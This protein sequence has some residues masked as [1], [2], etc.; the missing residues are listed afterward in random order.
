MQQEADRQRAGGKRIGLVPTMG[1]L[2]EG[3]TS[4][5][6]EAR[7]ISDIVVLS[8]F[9]NP[10]QF[11][12]TEDLA[13]YPR[14]FERDKRAAEEAGV[15]ILFLPGER[16]VYPGDFAT[17]IE[18]QEVSRILEGK[19]RPTH[20][21]GVTTIV[22]KLFNIC[23]PNVAVFGQ[24]DAQQA[25]IIRKMARDLN[26]DVDILVASIVRE[27]DG[28]AMSSRNI[29]LSPTDRDNATVLFKSLTFAER[30]IANGSHDLKGLRARM[31]KM[32]Q[33]AGSPKIDYIA[34]LDPASFR[35]VETLAGPTVL[36]ALA[37]RF[38]E[39]RLIDNMLVPC[40]K[41]SAR[42]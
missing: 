9:V 7:R 5:I 33:S 17:F 20:F 29:Y 18:E 12:P 30:E 15:D 34:F 39:T 24:K 4:L 42:T 32:I 16:D 25:F 14:D 23:K 38:G 1:Y 11:A 26:V 41:T 22:G 35:E 10:T 31:E 27:E 28:L 8:I 6:R 13:R 3:H 2:Y 40:G 37:A 21:R 19:Y 36:I